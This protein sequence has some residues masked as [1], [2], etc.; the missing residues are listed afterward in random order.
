[1]IQ[2]LARTPCGEPQRGNSVAVRAQ[3]A[4]TGAAEL[5]AVW[6][7]RYKRR[8][9]LATC[10]RSIQQESATLRARSGCQADTFP[11][12]EAL[13]AG[14]DS[15]APSGFAIRKLG[16]SFAAAS[17]AAPDHAHSTSPR[18]W[19]LVRRRLRATTVITRLRSGLRG[20]AGERRS[21]INEV[22]TPVL[23]V[24]NPLWRSSMAGPS[25]TGF[26]IEK[27][28]RR[29]A[30]HWS[31]G[32]AWLTTATLADEGLDIGRGHALLVP[33]VTGFLE[34]ISRLGRGAQC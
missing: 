6:R 28:R 13:F 32:L 5:P 33:Q 19:V 8:R 27:L 26:R 18:S 25:R 3:S 10:H 2:G 23:R 24:S 34:C 21:A 20:N 15:A 4:R 1:M 11:V 7:A 12:R 22:P 29:R 31:C 9:F 30:D 14:L 16:R 17:Q